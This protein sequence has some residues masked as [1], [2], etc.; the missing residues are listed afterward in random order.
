MIPHI[1][2]IHALYECEIYY[3]ITENMVVKY[4]KSG[5][6]VQKKCW[7]SMEISLLSTEII[8][9]KYGIPFIVK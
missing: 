9:V 5:C 4:G 6:E 3:Y 8:A 1:E 7:L 2:E